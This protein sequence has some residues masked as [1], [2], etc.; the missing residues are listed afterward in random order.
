M[1]ER[2]LYQCDICKVEYSSKTE[3][4]QCEA[5]HVAPSFKKVEGRY[6]GMNV[7]SGCDQYP[8]KVIVT[9]ADGAKI[10]FKR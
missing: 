6:K 2:K 8:Y 7:R 10:E 9:M 5:Y 3:A 1:T 4:Q